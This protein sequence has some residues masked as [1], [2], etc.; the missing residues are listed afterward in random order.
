MRVA[1]PEFLERTDIEPSTAEAPPILLEPLGS[2][3]VRE[4]ISGLLDLERTPSNL[5]GRIEAA[6]QGNPLFVEQLVAAWR[7][8]GGLAEDGQVADGDA[9]PVPPT[10]KAL[11]RSRLDVLPLAERS[12]LERGS[13]VGQ[14][15]YRGAVAD[16]GSEP[17]LDALD[18]RLDRLSSRRFVRPDMSPFEGDDAWAFVHLLVR[19]ATYAGMLKRARS[20]LHERFAGWLRERAGDRLPE[21]EEIVGYHLERA[22]VL[23]RELGPLDDA[24]VQIGVRAAEVLERC[25]Q[26]ATEGSRVSAAISLLERAAGCLPTDSPAS[27]IR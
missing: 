6:A 8:A 26:R 16:L 7:D 1:R 24:G 11:L 15:F 22:Y 10:I 3:D 21:F 17:D 2:S 27:P 12:L 4:L 25:A 14:V 23:R 20:E 19:D 9:L 18:G 13:V 5:V